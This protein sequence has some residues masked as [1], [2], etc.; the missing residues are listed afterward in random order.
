MGNTGQLRP[1]A[2]NDRQAGAQVERVSKPARPIDSFP[3]I[4]AEELKALQEADLTLEA[5]RGMVGKE[6]SV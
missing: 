1:E 4:S 3:E 6:E 5:L 2:T